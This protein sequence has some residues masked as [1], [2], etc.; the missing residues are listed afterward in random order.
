MTIAVGSDE[1]NRASSSCGC[2]RKPVLARYGSSKIT[3]LSTIR[4][5]LRN[6]S[7][8]AIQLFQ[9]GSLGVGCRRRRS[10]DS[11]FGDRGSCSVVSTS[12]SLAN[13][14]LQ[15]KFHRLELEL[16]IDSR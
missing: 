13:T 6:Q 16:A 8:S 9:G 11:G 4:T 5:T 3:G 12:E 1:A 15:S 7:A 14:L 10:S 2:L